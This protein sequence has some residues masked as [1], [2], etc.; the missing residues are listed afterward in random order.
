[1]AERGSRAAVVAC[2]LRAIVQGHT[3][4][5]HGVRHGDGE[6]AL[7]RMPATIAVARQ[8]ALSDLHGVVAPHTSAIVRH[9]RTADT[10]AKHKFAAL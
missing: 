5:A 10:G 1:M 7:E 9:E 4:Y 6:R 3:E 2:P 8:V